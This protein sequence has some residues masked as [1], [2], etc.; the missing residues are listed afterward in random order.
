M[1]IKIKYYKNK[2]LNINGIM[3]II[4][5]IIILMI[6]TI[7]ITT[8]I[9]LIKIVFNILVDGSAFLGQVATGTVKLR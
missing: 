2:L 9:I 6:I 7:I 3:V 5:M 1:L 8:I 4:L